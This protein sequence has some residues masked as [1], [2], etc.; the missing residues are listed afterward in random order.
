MSKVGWELELANLCAPNW[1]GKSYW[2]RSKHVCALFMAE[3]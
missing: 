2:S 1:A 3:L